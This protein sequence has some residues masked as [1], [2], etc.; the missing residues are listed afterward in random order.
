M[1]LRAQFLRLVVVAIALIHGRASAA[2]IELSGAEKLR[3][4]VKWQ[5]GGAL[6]IK[7]TEGRDV[8]VPAKGWQRVSYGRAKVYDLP[9]LDAS[10]LGDTLPEYVVGL[11]PGVIT[12]DGSFVAGGV[13]TGDD[14][15]FTF[16]GGK[17]SL[18]SLR[19]GVVLFHHLSPKRLARL[20]GGRRGVLLRNGDFVDGEFQSLTNGVLNVSSVLFGKRAI[21]ATLD[22]AALVVRPVTPITAEFEVRLENG[23]VVLTRSLEFAPD[24]PQ[25]REIAWQRLKLSAENLREVRRP[26]S[27]TGFDAG[28]LLAPA[29][30]FAQF[31]RERERFAEEAVARFEAAN[32]TRTKEAK[33]LAETINRTEAERLAKVQA[34]SAQLARE[35]V[36]K[37]ARVQLESEARKKG[38][39]AALKE[40]R[41]ML[42][43][44]ETEHRSKGRLLAE[45]QAVHEKSTNAAMAAIK[46]HEEFKE[47]LEKLGRENAEKIKAAR[48]AADAAKV[49]G[50]KSVAEAVAQ[51]KAGAD[52]VTALEQKLAKATAERSA[53]DLAAKTARAKAERVTADNLVKI[54]TA[55]MAR[56]A[57]ESARLTAQA[58]SQKA[59]KDLAAADAALAD[60][61]QK[62]MQATTGATA[63]A[64]NLELARGVSGKAAAEVARRTTE[65]TAGKAAA[66]AAQAQMTAKAQALVTAK[67][68]AVAVTTAADRA[69]DTAAKAAAVTGTAVEQAAGVMAEKSRLLAAAKSA[70]K[71][72]PEAIKAAEQALT[73]ATAAKTAADNALKTA[74]TALDAATADAD[75]KIRQARAAVTAAEQAV[76]AGSEAAQKAGRELAMA[77][78]ALNVATAAAGK[79]SLE[80]AAAEKAAKE[81]KAAADKLVADVARCTTERAAAKTAAGTAA[82]TLATKEQAAM[83][84]KLAADKVGTE[85][86]SARMD[87]EKA[88]VAAAA[89][90]AKAGADV[91]ELTMRLT[92][93]R[94]AAGRLA[95][96]VTAATARAT[97]ERT[98]AEAVHTRVKAAAE[99]EMAALL[100]RV[101]SHGTERNTAEA[102]AKTRRVTLDQAELAMKA[103][104]EK[105]KKDQAVFAKAQALVDA[106]MADT[107]AREKAVLQWGELAE[108]GVAEARYQLGV[109][110]LGDAKAATKYVDAYVW[111]ALAA[112][113]G[114][115]PAASLRAKLA[116]VMTEEQLGD[117]RRRVSNVE[118]RAN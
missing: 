87:S 58:A 30:T 57:A 70:A 38:N 96:A 61:T 100:A 48:M 41:L 78:A 28:M 27:G 33:Q 83:A 25:F 31:Q 16:A 4:E 90:L 115:K 109:A 74:R 15:L 13:A 73:T 47:R 111:L 98:E 39:A 103:A 51:A 23:S 45:A 43:R 86:E 10:V 46:L 54:R 67:A 105:L 80:L 88:A 7:T 84:A 40:M 12:A 26:R 2:T 62:S 108:R 34:A 107:A 21:N 113:G 116:E 36:E 63:A 35:E 18:S 75:A 65:K 101:T 44:T 1:A 79:S 72:M 55:T 112:K 106:D 118:S 8:P 32:A 77:D 50:D 5:P 20:A 17:F 97:R 24:G 89:V 11:P 99:R 9:G 92:T 110:L 114:N 85:A 42:E 53:A 52:E 29:P 56:D 76:T 91:T 71:P 102:L 37:I 117:A 59:V 66:D 95:L 64:K 49:A 14:S 22:A 94:A 69:R 60:F 6:R 82:T 68:S 93:A 81:S 19:V 104:D 3:G